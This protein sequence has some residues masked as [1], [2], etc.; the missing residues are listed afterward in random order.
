M[1]KLLILSLL[2]FSGCSH[3]K[4]TGSMC[5]KIRTEGGEMPQE[6]REYDEA[7][8]DKAFNKVTE[9]KKVSNK[10]IE[11]DNQGE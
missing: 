1:T 3:F 7:K 11:F 5:D 4:V 2:L 10:D 6:C 8:A 9:D